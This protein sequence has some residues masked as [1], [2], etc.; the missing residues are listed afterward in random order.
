V[1]TPAARR[2]FFYAIGLREISGVID[3]DQYT[4]GVS[5]I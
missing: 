5:G 2:A 1:K 3:F 4:D